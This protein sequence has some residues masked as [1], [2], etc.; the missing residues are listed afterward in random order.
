MAKLGSILAMAGVTLVAAAAGVGGTMGVQQWLAHASGAT[1]TAASAKPAP[2]KPIYFADLSD[3]VVSLP[4]QAGEPA[5]SFV[6]FDMQFSTYDQSAL[7][8]FSTVQPIVKAQIINLLMG[9]TGDALQD[10]N[11]R[12]TLI[13]NCLDAANNILKKNTGAATAPFNAAYI[14]SLV[15]QD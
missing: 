10:P 12:T 15:V 5:T 1:A 9:E 6:Q 8:S 11:V 14:T 7:A 4:P 2:P 3:V 13:Q